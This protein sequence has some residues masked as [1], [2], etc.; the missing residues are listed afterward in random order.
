MNLVTNGEQEPTQA[1][2]IV[3]LSRG[4]IKIWGLCGIV[5]YTVKSSASLAPAY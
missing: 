3:I 5:L 1:C 2:G 4:A